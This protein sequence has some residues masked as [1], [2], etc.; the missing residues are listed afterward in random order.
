M[1]V[2]Y[3]YFGNTHLCFREESDEVRVF[4]RPAAKSARNQF[5]MLWNLGI[6]TIDNGLNLSEEWVNLI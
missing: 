5:W 2:G 3:H 4:F 6:R 1:V